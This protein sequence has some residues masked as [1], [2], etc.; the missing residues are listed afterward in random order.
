MIGLG[1][2]KNAL[3]R[4]SVPQGSKWDN[5]NERAAASH[6]VDGAKPDRG[7]GGFRFLDLS[8]FCLEMGRWWCDWWRIVIAHNW[9]RKPISVF[10]S[11]LSQINRQVLSLVIE[12]DVNGNGKLDFDEFM[13]MMRKQVNILQIAQREHLSPGRT[14]G[15]LC[16]VERS[17]QNIWQVGSWQVDQR[18]ESFSYFRDGNGFIDA[19]E[20][21]K[22]TKIVLHNT[23]KPSSNLLKCA[24][25]S[26][27]L[28]R[29]FWKERTPYELS[30]HGQTRLNWQ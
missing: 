23:F 20:L 17:L 21:K 3:L 2:D 15:Q 28:C 16:R 19:A 30:K 6:E 12:Y 24:K 7:R 10:A 5:I 22:V 18:A 9:S 14:P 1:S 26:Q 13:E 25:R 8:S 27:T 4:L 11:N 29:M